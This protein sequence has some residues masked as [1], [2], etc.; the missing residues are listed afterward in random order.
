MNSFPLVAKVCLCKSNQN[1]CTLNSGSDSEILVWY[2]LP[3]SFHI[4]GGWNGKGHVSLAGAE[5]PH[6]EWMGGLQFWGGAAGA[7]CV[8]G[9]RT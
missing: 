2:S 8:K 5:T 9:H 6:S 3:F 4:F 7:R 1:C